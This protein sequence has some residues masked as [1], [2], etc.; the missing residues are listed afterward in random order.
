MKCQ[1]KD[2]LDSGKYNRN[3]TERER[4]K[5]IF[6]PLPCHVMSSKNLSKWHLRKLTIINKKNKK[7]NTNTK[8]NGETNSFWIHVIPQSKV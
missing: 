6:I 5:V 1:D 4:E 7:Q 3:V 8:R 2:P